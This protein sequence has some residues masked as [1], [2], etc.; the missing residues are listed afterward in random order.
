LLLATAASVATA[1]TA[2][3]ATAAT[4]ARAT[5][6]TR[7]AD[8]LEAVPAVYGTV[9]AGLEGHLGRLAAV[10]ANHVEQLPL[11]TGCAVEAA[12]TATRVA[13]T[14]VAAHSAARAAALGLGEAAGGVEL[15]ILGAECEL[16]STIRAG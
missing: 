8:T 6:A 15:L 11:G 2:V 13:F 10:A 5:A 16:L 3:A 14:L 4:G 12:T 7:T 1:T 9:A